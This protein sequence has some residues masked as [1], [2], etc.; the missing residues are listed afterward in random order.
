MKSSAIA[1]FCILASNSSVH[2]AV[3]LVQVPIACGTLSEVG[4][5]LSLRM[6]GTTIIGKGENSKGQDV[7]V[8]FS[9]SGRWALVTKFSAGKVCVVAS[10]RNWTDVAPAAANIF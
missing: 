7:A 2:A 10:G 5:L 6:Q 3:D 4:D 1:T 9:G 8:L